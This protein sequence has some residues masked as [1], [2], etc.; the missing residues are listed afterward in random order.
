MDFALKSPERDFI[1]YAR[2]VLSMMLD[3]S[4][5]SLAKLDLVRTIG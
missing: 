1:E 3:H 4:G 2:N 5:L